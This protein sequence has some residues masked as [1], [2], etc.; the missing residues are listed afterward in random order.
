M[1][2]YQSFF[3]AFAVIGIYSLA[4]AEASKT[5]ESGYVL[6]KEKHLGGGKEIR[7]IGFEPA[8]IIDDLE[9]IERR[10]HLSFDQREGSGGKYLLK[11]VPDEGLTEKGRRAVDI[12]PLWL[13]HDLA[14]LFKRIENKQDRWA[15]LVIAHEG[16]RYVDELIFTIAHSSAW[17]LK[18]IFADEE[19]YLQNV[20]VLYD[21]DEELDYVEIV[22]CGRPGVDEDY[23]STTRY[24]TMRDGEKVQVELEREYYYWYVVHPKLSGEGPSIG[25]SGKFWREYLFYDVEG[26][27]S[28][29]TFWVLKEPNIIT[30]DDVSG[31]GYRSY[32]YLTGFS[33]FV[34][35]VITDAETG[36]PVLT[37]IPWKRGAILAT[38]LPLEKSEYPGQEKLLRNC[39]NYGNGEMSLKDM[40]ID[41]QDDVKIA[42]IKD[43]D[44]WGVPS[45][46]NMVNE[47]GFPYVVYSSEDL[48]SMDEIPLDVEKIIIPSDQTRSF[49][50]TISRN[51]EKIQEWLEARNILEFHGA[52]EESEDWSDL[53]IPGGFARTPLREDASDQFKLSKYPLLKDVLKLADVVW[54]EQIISLPAGREFSSSC[55]AVDILGN[56]QGQVKF[57][58]A[59]SYQ[60]RTIQPEL[61]AFEHDGNCGET[62]Y[63]L[64]AAGRTALIPFCCADGAAE[65]H[66]WNEFYDNGWHF[67]DVGREGG[68]SNIGY[69]GGKMDKDVGGRGTISM[70]ARHR[71]DTLDI[72][73]TR[74]YT[75]YSTLIVNVNDDNGHPVDGAVVKVFTEYSHADWPGYPDY[76]YILNASTDSQ[77]MC[78]FN[79]GDNRN[80]YIRVESPIGDYPREN[81]EDVIQIISKNVPDRTYYWGCNLEGELPK[82]NGTK[83]EYQYDYTIYLADIEFNVENELIYGL[84]TGLGYCR[85]SETGVIDY[86]ICDA[87]NLARYLNGDDFEA[88]EYQTDVA[89]GKNTLYVSPDDAFY[90]VLS[91]D[92]CIKNTQ[93]GVIKVDYKREVGPAVQTLE[94]LATD[95]KLHPG[96]RMIISLNDHAPI[97]LAAG[98]LDSELSETRG[99]ELYFRALVMDPDGDDDI[100]KVELVIDGERAEKFF[101]DDGKKADETAGD[102]L[103]S[104]NLVFFPNSIQKGL[105]KEYGIIAEDLMGRTSTIWPKLHVEDEKGFSPHPNYDFN[106]P[107]FGEK[108]MSLARFQ[109]EMNRYNEKPLILAGGYG[110]TSLTSAGGTLKYFAI[111]P[112][113][114]D[115]SWKV[116]ILYEMNPTGIYLYDT[117]F[118]FDL[119][120]GRVYAFTSEM[121]SF[122]P[123]DY[124]FELQATD[125]FGSESVVF[126]YFEVGE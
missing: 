114:S 41:P 60:P 76:I 29:R 109:A 120:G 5:I 55:S 92:R 10:E 25:P 57:Y 110:D 36:E 82:L 33:K 42:I 24:W 91:N 113:W 80:F 70:I 58:W 77:G 108:I 98:F 65:D 74:D 106:I 62:H 124:V 38:V 125:G 3:I 118:D 78:S 47:L 15:D 105:H 67:F 84:T 11:Q 30:E 96:E 44:P 126:P 100:K 97:I 35:N 102:S 115:S 81:K 87:P 17:Y 7:S 123:G 45:V 95:F 88:I 90:I 73:V 89:E 19:A 13:K 43:R 12:A 14:D 20:Q 111:L 93:E 85:Y 116:E 99:G 107:L 39:V 79:L 112:E 49:Y 37:C 32:G 23:Y 83:V 48:D 40:K 54:D 63:L 56:W 50:E 16:E 4:L 72:D 122:P 31:W 51:R 71:P 117:G 104:M 68:P 2:K 46:E 34:W 18:Q 75:S 103:Y 66:V 22:D 28:Y 1:R 59:R 61:I 119:F 26:E 86:F 53:P 94:T 121:S 6:P 8:E 27:R 9:R 52:C 21:I 64:G 101:R 69:P